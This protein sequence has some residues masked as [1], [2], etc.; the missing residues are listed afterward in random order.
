MSKGVLG[1][2][3]GSQCLLTFIHLLL[4][5]RGGRGGSLLL[6]FPLS[7]GL[8]LLFPRAF[9]FPWGVLFRLALCELFSWCR[10]RERSQCPA[11]FPTPLSSEPG[12]GGKP[13]GAATKASRPCA[14]LP[15]APCTSWS[16]NT[17]PGNKHVHHNFCTL[18][19]MRENMRTYKI[20]VTMWDT[21]HSVGPHNP[22]A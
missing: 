19:S 14:A 16:K 7:L 20:L 15:S 10:E 12:N 5:S 2:R 6:L 18:T 4:G 17:T 13:P 22:K 8:L 3:L 11:S 1:L 21:L 9:L